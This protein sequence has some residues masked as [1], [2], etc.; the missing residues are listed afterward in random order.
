MLNREKKQ[1]RRNRRPNVQN[2]NDTFRATQPGNDFARGFERK[3]PD[4]IDVSDDLLSIG[5]R[6]S[7][8]VIE[9]N[10]PTGDYVYRGL[11]TMVQGTEKTVVTGVTAT[12]LMA[13][14]G[15]GWHYVKS[16]YL[17]KLFSRVR[18]EADG[19]EIFDFDSWERFIQY[20]RMFGWDGRDTDTHEFLGFGWPNVFRDGAAVEA[21]YAL[22]TANIRDLR[23]KL[24]TTSDW[25]SEMEL[26]MPV[27]YSP[28]RRNAAHVISRQTYNRTLATAGKHAIDDIRIDKRI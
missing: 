18:L 14:G 28:V 17:G 10:F 3:L 15:D 5:S 8:G 25:K 16:A 12:N 9:V 19:I 13:F 26:R 23:M 20:I 4:Y 27:W 11:A 24:Y 22:G 2:E 6:L 7:G 21:L 1:T